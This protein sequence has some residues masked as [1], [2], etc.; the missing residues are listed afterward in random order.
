MTDGVV[1]YKVG[2]LLDAIRL[3]LT[4]G[5]ASLN[6][7][8][9]SKADKEDLARLE[10]EMATKASKSD[11]DKIRHTVESLEKD[12]VEEEAV[13]RVMAE[14]KELS[15]AARRWRIGVIAGVA[16]AIPW[17]WIIGRV[18]TGHGP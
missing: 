13:R 2:E 12:R 14:K 3:D 17:A 11:V 4:A 5:F 16:W 1:E 6:T 8:L 9:D 18:L 15:T 7:K 10:K